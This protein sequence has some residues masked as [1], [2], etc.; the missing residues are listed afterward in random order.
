MSRTEVQRLLVTDT[1]NDVERS[2]P[3]RKRQKKKEDPKSISKQLSRQIDCLVN[4][5]SGLLE[6][7]V[8]DTEGSND[9]DPTSSSEPETGTQ[10]LAP[11]QRLSTF[12]PSRSII[13]SETETECT[14][15]L[16]P[17]DVRIWPVLYC[18]LQDLRFT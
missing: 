5:Q 17:N 4:V 11:V 15:R 13:L 8:K 18:T 1:R 10:T 16:H 7:E 14:V 2:E 12:D 9:S 6:P 3:S